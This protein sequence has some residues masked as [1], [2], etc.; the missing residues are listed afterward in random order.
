MEYIP[1]CHGCN[2]KCKDG[3]RKCKHITKDHRSKVAALDAAGH[4]QKKNSNNSN[5]TGTIN[6]AAGEGDKDGGSG[7]NGVTKATFS[8][9][10][11]LTEG[12]SG[13]NSTYTELLKITG[14]MHAEVGMGVED[15]MIYEDDGSWDGDVLANLGAA[16]FLQVQGE[17]PEKASL[18][19]SGWMVQSCCG[20]KPLQRLKTPPTSIKEGD[21][22]RD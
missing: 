5:K 4:F 12:I 9:H 1:T 3:C 2:R 17:K 14:H 8:E 20:T 15:G 6:I 10:S 11:E 16:G 18:L 7:S 19:N 21:C 22:T 13:P